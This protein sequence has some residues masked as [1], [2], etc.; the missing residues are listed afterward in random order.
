[1]LVSSFFGLLSWLA[2]GRGQVLHLQLFCLRN[3]LGLF[4]RS[5]VLS[6]SLSHPARLVM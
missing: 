1:V 3:S 5:L 2:E 4:S 6:L